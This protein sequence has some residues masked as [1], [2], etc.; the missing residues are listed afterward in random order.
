MPLGSD[1]IRVLTLCA[2][3]AGS[4]QPRSEEVLVE[5]ADTAVVNESVQ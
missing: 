4:S 5:H 2:L 3:H 1:A